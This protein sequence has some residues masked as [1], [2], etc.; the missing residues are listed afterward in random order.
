MD[1]KITDYSR[2]SEKIRNLARINDFFE[3]DAAG[4][5]HV[6][7]FQTMPVEAA[8]AFVRFIRRPFAIFGIYSPGF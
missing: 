8:I 5:F 3:L 2:N 6:S 4:N 1:D 7:D